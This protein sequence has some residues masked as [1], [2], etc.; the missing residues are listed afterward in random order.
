MASVCLSA[1]KIQWGPYTP[2]GFGGSKKSLVLIGLSNLRQ[3]IISFVQESNRNRPT[4]VISLRKYKSEGSNSHVQRRCVAKTVFSL[5][6]VTGK[7][8]LITC[9]WHCSN[10]KI[11]ISHWEELGLFSATYACC[12]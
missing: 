7:L 3:K 4:S 9:S 12:H 1:A 11:T 5:V 2:P 10:H 6:Y 8:L